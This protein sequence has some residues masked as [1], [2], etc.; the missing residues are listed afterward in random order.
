[1]LMES[2][3]LCCAS[4]KASYGSFSVFKVLDC[5]VCLFHV[6][7]LLRKAVSLVFISVIYIANFSS[8]WQ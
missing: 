1:M 5:V 7:R 4:V 2:Q 6:E 3:I 8:E